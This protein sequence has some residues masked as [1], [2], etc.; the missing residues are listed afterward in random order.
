MFS[1]CS[2]NC[3]LRPKCW[4]QKR[5]GAEVKNSSDGQP[6]LRRR[7]KIDA[8]LDEDLGTFLNILT[9]LSE[10]LRDLGYPDEG[11]ILIDVKKDILKRLAAT[12]ERPN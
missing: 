9:N 3:S 6:P 10:T 2:A 7:P 11:A 4:K 5:K 12:I 8:V 1:G